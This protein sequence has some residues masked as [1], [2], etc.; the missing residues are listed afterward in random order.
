MNNE[1]NNLPYTGSCLCGAVQYSVDKIEKQMAHCHCTMCRKFH[2]A[3]F[4]TFGEARTE[5]FHWVN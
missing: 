1:S 3:A 2:G 5:N 4:A